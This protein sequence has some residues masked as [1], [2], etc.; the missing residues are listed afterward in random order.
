MSQNAKLRHCMN[1][2]AANSMLI[3]MLRLTAHAEADPVS[4]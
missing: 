2:A 1:N 3:D 4:P